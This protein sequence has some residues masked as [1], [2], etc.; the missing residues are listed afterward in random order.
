MNK[1]FNY[2]SIKEILSRIL[3]HPLLQ[4]INLE[5][6]IQYTVDF[7]G[8]FGLPKMY[9]DRQDEI[10][11]DNYRG[12]IPCNCISINGVKDKDS[13]RMLRSMTDVFKSGTYE[14]NQELS[15]KT[16]GQCIFTSF[17]E[18]DIIISYKTLPVDDEG[19]PLLIDNAVFLK[20]LEA[21]IKKEAFTVLF[22]M[23]RIGANVIQNAEQR[24]AWLAGQLQSE[25]TMPSI[26]E[27]ESLKGMWCSLLQKNN[28]HE[29]GFN[30]IG[31]REKI[32]VQ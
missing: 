20:C 24:Y 1:E 2:I 15:F 29:R 13:N 5:Q 17:K 26:A 30:H 8:I 14:G 21:Y 18:G 12:L 11:I 23:G 27:M 16:Q 10:H 22:D 25:L 31:D 7:I 28:E 4:D 9:Q 3:R 32:K 19:L 6:A